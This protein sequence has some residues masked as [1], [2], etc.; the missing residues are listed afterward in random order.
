[1][2]YAG[3]DYHT[4]KSYVSLLDD[5]G[6]E[7]GGANLESGHELADFLE[8]LDGVQV[9]FEAGYGWPRLVKLLANSGVEL[10]MCHPEENRRIATDRRKSDSRDANNLAM[11]LKS[12]MYKKAYMPDDA[13]RD[14][15]QLVRGR[16]YTVRKITRLR[17]QV[18]S[19]LAYAGVQKVPANIF[20]MKN[21][22]YFD[23]IELPESTRIVLDVNLESFDAHNE[24]L[25][26]LD[27]RM[28][29]MNRVEPRARLLKT[30]PGVGDVTARTLLSEIGDIARFKTAKSLA[31]YSGLVPKQRQSGES[32]R[33]MGLTKEGSAHIRAVMVQAAWITIRLDPA[34]REFYDELK[35]RK[36]AQTA[37]CAVARKLVTAAWYILK[38]DVPYRA[39]KPVHESKPAVARG[40]VSPEA[41]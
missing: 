9:L 29:E 28:K 6:V 2:L 4:K 36:N 13:V 26:R 19:L 16:A 22:Y 18:R 7:I 25:K 31:C 39:R 3:L 23:T 41:D 27:A 12:G 5:A 15:R 37:I 33:S 17:N 34:F 24:M 30:I 8:G 14:E 38:N 11:Y 1:M 21:R 10:N 40:T 35:A 20:A 32:M